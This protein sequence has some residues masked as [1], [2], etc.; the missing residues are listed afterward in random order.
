MSVKAGIG[1][2]RNLKIEEAAREAAVRAI[3]VVGKDKIDLAI[4]ISTID[5]APEK[6]VPVVRDILSPQ[7]LLGCSTAGIILSNSV[8]TQG[9]AVL[10]IVS[11]SIK[12]GIGD[13]DGVSD[14]N[15]YDSGITLARRCLTDFGKYNRKAIVLFV[16]GSLKN[17]TP[18]ITGIQDIFGNVFP[19]IGGSSSDTFRFSS[20]F[21]IFQDR[22]YNH[23]ALGLLLGGSMD[24]GIGTGHGWR[25]LG[26]PRII[27]EAKGNII[28]K[29]DGK[30]AAD[31]YEQYLGDESSS[32][33]SNNLSQMA[34]LYPLGILVG[35][36]NEYLLRNAVDILADGSIVCQGD[37]PEG[38]EV[39]IMI[40]N[41]ES[42]KNASLEAAEQAKQALGGKSP[43]LV[44]IFESIARL[45]LLGRAAYQEVEL[46]KRVFGDDVSII[47]MYSNGEFCPFESV[48][49]FKRP[50]FQN[51]SIVVA[52]F[53]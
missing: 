45:K 22:V 7:R 46:I 38:A 29:I 11:D 34:I 33:Y 42:C 17:N 8:E 2:S 47:G 50:S 4:V 32:L 49:E 48:G 36:K 24:I 10:V 12:I 14:G 53:A 23:S 43:V 44:V 51:E 31:L 26:K 39:H 15:V 25:P 6:T 18:L 13:V 27:N 35:E 30:M 37:V 16:D 19:V 3:E 5:Y 1:F 28:K 52:A 20:T 21:Q 40:G 41:K 9:I